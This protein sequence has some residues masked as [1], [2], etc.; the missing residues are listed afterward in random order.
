RIGVDRDRDG[1]LD[2]DEAAGGALVLLPASKLALKGTAGPRGKMTFLART[3]FAPAASRIVPPLPGS[4]GDP[5][6]GGGALMVYNAARITTDGVAVDLPA[7]GWQRL[8]S[9]A[10]PRG[11]TFR[12]PGGTGPVRRLKITA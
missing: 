6:L 9:A 5:S 8:G 1:I 11:W 2:G 12:S 7:A 4:A 3:D 10:A